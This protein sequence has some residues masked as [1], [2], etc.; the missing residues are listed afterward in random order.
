MATYQT[1]LHEPR[2]RDFT[3]R[4]KRS[5][6]REMLVGARRKA[7]GKQALA[8]L[9]AV[10]LPAFAAPADWDRFQIGNAGEARAEVRPMP[11]EQA[12]SSFPGSAFYYLDLEMPKVRMGEGIHSDADNPLPADKAPSAS[13]QFASPF[14][15]DNSGIDRT[16]ALDCLTAAVYYEAASEADSGQRAV[17]QVVLNRVAHSAYPDTV[18]GVVYQGSQRRTGCQFT[19]TCDGSLARRPNR[20]FWLR[21]ENVARDAL[22]GYVY[23]PIGLATH[24]HT[25][26]VNPYWAPSLH[27]LGTIGAHRFYSFQG[28]AGRRGA[29]RFAYLGGEPSV[30]GRMTAPEARTPE[31]ALDPVQLQLAYDEGLRRAEAAS[32]LTAGAQSSAAAPVYS[33][34]VQSHGGEA[35]YRGSKLPETT[36]VKPEFLNSGRWI[37]QPTD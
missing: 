6:Q 10:A 19:F 14:R 35:L 16:R 5:R 25:V 36:G 13:A 7:Q 34:E 23:T 3:A 27:Y 17:A 26:A 12:G 9:G 30:T 37:T 29:F 24:Y 15:I 32:L 2:P 31:A 4:L 20:M 28:A 21:A 18:C 33:Q 22:A 8:L 1:A 11:F